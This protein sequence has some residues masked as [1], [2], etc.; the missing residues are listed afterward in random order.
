MTLPRLSNTSDLVT[1]LLIEED[2]DDCCHDCA[3]SCCGP[4]EP[5]EFWSEDEFHN[6]IC[7]IRWRRA[8]VALRR[9]FLWPLRIFTFFGRCIHLDENAAYDNQHHA[10]HG[11]PARSLTHEQES[12]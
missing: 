12:E 1:V 3:L 6:Y 10:Q 9:F 2:E 5:T 11:D 7:Y 4:R 8:L